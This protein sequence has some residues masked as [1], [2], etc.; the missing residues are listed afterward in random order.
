[1][2]DLIQRLRV[3]YPFPQTDALMQ[4]AADE[5]EFRDTQIIGYQSEI[6]RLTGQITGLE[7]EIE[8]LNGRLHSA[9]A[10]VTELEKQLAEARADYHHELSKQD[11]PEQMPRD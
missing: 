8:R 3:R 7:H 10:A 9:S 6:A 2:S 1:M 4:E 5:I 11:L